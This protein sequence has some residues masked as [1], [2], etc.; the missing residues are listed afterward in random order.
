[1][2]KITPNLLKDSADCLSE[3]IKK[4]G[5]DGL[6]FSVFLHDDISG[7]T[8]YVSNTTKEM[9]IKAVNNW[10][11]KHLS[12]QP[13]QKS[14]PNQAFQ[15]PIVSRFIGKRLYDI[16]Y[17]S[18]FNFKLHRDAESILKDIHRYKI[19]GDAQ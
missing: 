10:G 5:L 14:I 4:N 2:N 13:Q 16:K 17:E 15:S 11:N 19:I 8:H 12:N 7:D 6:G 9:M 1:M 18:E 3:F